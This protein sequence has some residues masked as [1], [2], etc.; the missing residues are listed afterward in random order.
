MNLMPKTHKLTNSA[1]PENE[2]ESKGRPIITAHSWCTVEA[3][4]FLRGA[5]GN[6]GGF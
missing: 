2:L 1:S 4:K 6:N 5:K 3:S